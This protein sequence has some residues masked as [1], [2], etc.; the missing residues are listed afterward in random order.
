MPYK[1]TECPH[2]QLKPLSCPFCGKPG[3]IFGDNFVG[4][5]DQHECCAN[6]DFGH[7]TG[8]EKGVPAVHWVIEAWNKRVPSE[9]STQT[10][11]EERSDEVSASADQPA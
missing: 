2:C 10:Q 7:W 11:L 9:A 4:C 1:A 5:E 3:M 8:E 6:I